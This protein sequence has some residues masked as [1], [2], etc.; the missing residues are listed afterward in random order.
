[1]NKLHFF[2]GEVSVA[3]I[4]S[5]ELGDQ[6]G[7]VMT[8]TTLEVVKIWFEFSPTDQRWETSV[9]WDVRRSSQPNHQV[10]GKARNFVQALLEGAFVRVN[11]TEESSSNGATTAPSSPSTSSADLKRKQWE[12]DFRK[13]AFL[14]GLSTSDLGRKINLGRGRPRNFTIVGAKPRNWKMPILVQGKRGGVYKITV[15]TAKAGLV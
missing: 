6:F 1:V 2:Q 9:T 4:L 11:K 14:W 15:E 8:A 13:N 3:E 7:S 5:V 10:S 12:D